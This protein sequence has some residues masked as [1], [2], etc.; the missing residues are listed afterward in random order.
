[1]VGDDS[2]DLKVIRN[3]AR[4]MDVSCV[5]TDISRDEIDA[6]VE[7][8]KKYRF[9]CAF[10]MP[11]Y[12]AYLKKGLE[13]E[14][15]IMVGGVVGFPSGA[16]T[17]A[18]KVNQVK[19]LVQ[20]GCNELDMVIQVSALKSKDYNIVY[21]DISSVVENARDIPVKAII[22]AAYLSDEEIVK[23]SEIAMS[24]G[25]AYIKTGTGWAGKPTSVEVVRIIKSVVG[26]RC[27]IKAAGGIRDLKTVMQMYDAGCNRFGVS[28]NSAVSIAEEAKGIISL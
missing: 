14:N 16:E 26:D 7:A 9:I 25:A 10:S 28:S 18:M 3:I 2:M 8:A 19:E 13:S 12:T 20:A 22:E 27:G 4:I 1:M 17:T 24:A 15:D 21:S 5:R 11:C 6:M 23:A